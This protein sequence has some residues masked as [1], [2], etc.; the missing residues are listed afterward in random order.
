MA[1]PQTIATVA[2]VVPTHNRPK[3]LVEAVES[4]LAQTF[5]DLQLVVVDEASDP[6]AERVVGP[7][8]PRLRVIRNDAPRGP[9]AARNQ[10][11]D[12]VSSRF[13]AFLDDDDRWLPT[14]LEECLAGFRAHPQAGMVFH[15][16][17][18][19]RSPADRGRP[20]YRL[21]QEPVKRMLT[22]QPPHV[23]AVLIR[24]AVHDAVRFD[25]AFPAA[26]DLDYMLRV[27]MEADVLELNRL[28]AVHGPISER[29]SAIALE[30]RIAGRERFREK[31]SELF[32]DPEVR[33]FHE[34]RLGHLHSRAGER[35]RAASAFVRA[36]RIRPTWSLP[37]KGLLG[38]PVPRGLLARLLER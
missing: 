32:E 26:A 30:R 23:D 9:A 34:L 10:G 35:M 2:V 21:V 3:L 13:V 8:D 5:S 19:F 28:L 6:P 29:V 14:K 15:R 27:A 22:R 33:A 12:A 18:S 7:T 37:W 31:H 24:R 25:E 38:L 36:L 20:I 11:V 4:V 17:G 16:M 1:G